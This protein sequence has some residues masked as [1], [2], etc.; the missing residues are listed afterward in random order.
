[1]LV[2]VIAQMG[3]ST[4]TLVINESI[5]ELLPVRIHKTDD[6]LTTE[7]KD[8]LANLNKFYERFCLTKDK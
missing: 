5:C 3:C 2:A 8:Q 6:W 7:T 1:M 4:S